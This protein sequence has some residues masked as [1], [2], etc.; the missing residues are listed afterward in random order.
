MAKIIK[1]IVKT[2]GMDEWFGCVYLC[3]YCKATGW[4]RESKYCFNCGKSFNL[5]IFDDFKGTETE[6]RK[7]MEKTK[8]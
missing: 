6:K 7:D 2:L 4:H 8:G 5:I 3:P 1:Q